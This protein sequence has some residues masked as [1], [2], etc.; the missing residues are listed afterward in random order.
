MHRTLAGIVALTVL[1]ADVHAQELPA[2]PV[3]TLV[4]ITVLPSQRVVGTLVSVAADSLVLG[5]KGSTLRLPMSTVTGL[6][7]PAGQ[8]RTGSTILGA[9]LGAMLGAV[10]GG[11]VGAGRS[12]DS[13]VPFIGSVAGAKQGIVVGSAVG[14]LAGGITG[15]HQPR[16]RWKEAPLPRLGLRRGARALGVTI[17]F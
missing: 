2:W 16:P 13:S 12:H 14:A 11:A 8:L 15:Y 3:G 17:G 4:R 1:A 6:E 7:V 5:Q 10:V 9:A